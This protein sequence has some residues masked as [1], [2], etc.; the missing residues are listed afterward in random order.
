MRQPSERNGPCE[1]K[2]P[3]TPLCPLTSTW[4][5]HE[6]LATQPDK[7]RLTILLGRYGRD[8]FY[9]RNQYELMDVATSPAKR[10]PNTPIYTIGKTGEFENWDDSKIAN[11]VDSMLSRWAPFSLLG[12]NSLNWRLCSDAFPPAKKSEIFSY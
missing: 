10:V 6:S 4:V 8:E 3:Y 11:W 7:T 1:P 2:R 5:Q 9:K 12:L